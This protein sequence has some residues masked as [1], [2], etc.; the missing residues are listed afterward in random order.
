MNRL[1]LAPGMLRISWYLPHTQCL[2]PG[3]R[4]VLWVQGCDRRC[5]G[6]IA[7][8]LQ[9]RSGGSMIAVPELAEQ[10][11]ETQGIEGLTISGGE[12]FLQAQPLADLLAIV[13][14][15]RPE[16]GVIVYTGFLYEDLLEE[17]E[18]LP[19]LSRTDLLIDGPYQIALDDGKGMRG[20]SNQ[21]LLFLTDRYKDVMLPQSRKTELR[22]AGDRMQLIGIPSVA[23]KEMLAVLHGGNGGIP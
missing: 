3:E 10:I 5:E 14:E 17:T 11:T 7:E 21:R 12:P 15:N 2:G 16:L 19:L 18:A 13:K 20:S 8:G 22:I 1:A 9:D 6:C 4:S 23:A